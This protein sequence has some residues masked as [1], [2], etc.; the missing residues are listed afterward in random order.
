MTY[1][2]PP[3]YARQEPRP[4]LWLPVLGL[5]AVLLITLFGCGPSAYGGGSP[6]SPWT[7]DAGSSAQGTPPAQPVSSHHHG[8]VCH[9]PAT[10]DRSGRIPRSLPEP[11]RLALDVIGSAA[12]LLPAV[13]TG[14]PPDGEQEGRRTGRAAL[15]RLCRWR[16]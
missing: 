9:G 3:L 10:T 8:P 1:H 2:P 11:V 13:A 5:A 15:I 14:R 12:V 16:T 6:Q 7:V 4:P